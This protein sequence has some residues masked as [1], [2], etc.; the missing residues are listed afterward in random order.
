MKR[1]CLYPFIP[2]V[3]IIIIV[4]S[5][6]YC[7]CQTYPV[8]AYLGAPNV[9]GTPLY[10]SPF[11]PS[12]LSTSGNGIYST[13]YSAPPQNPLPSGE[14]ETVRAM[15]VKDNYAYYIKETGVA[16]SIPEQSLI[17][18]DISNTEKPVIVK[19]IPLDYPLYDII[20][21]GDYLYWLSDSFLWDM[22]YN[23]NVDEYILGAIDISNPVSP[24]MADT[25]KLRFS[26]GTGPFNMTFSENRLYIVYRKIEGNWDDVT[27]SI[28]T[29]DNSNP[30]N[31][32][33]LSMGSVEIDD[34]TDKVCI[35]DNLAFLCCSNIY[36]FDIS[37]PTNPDRVS[38]IRHG[39]S[40]FEDIEVFGDFLL[41]AVE[42]EGLRIM[43]IKDISSPQLITSLE[44]SWPK[45]IIIKDHYAYISDHC[46]GLYVVDLTDPEKPAVLSGYRLPSFKVYRSTSNSSES[47]LSDM[48]ITDGLALTLSYSN[49]Q[50]WDISERG[51]IQK[52][53]TLGA[54]FEQDSVTESIIPGKLI[55]LLSHTAQESIDLAQNGNSLTFGVDPLDQLNRKYGV[56]RI[57]QGESSEIPEIMEDYDNYKER[58]Y[59]IEFQAGEDM[60]EVWD[61][62]MDNPYCLIAEFIYESNFYLN[63]VTGSPQA[64]VAEPLYGRNVGGFF[65]SPSAAAFTGI[66]FPQTPPA[67]NYSLFGL[68]NPFQQNFGIS[69]GIINNITPWTLLS[70]VSSPVNWQI[71]SQSYRF[72][73]PYSLGNSSIS[74]PFSINFLKPAINPINFNNWF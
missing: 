28:I 2:L 61:A 73:S 33:Q 46:K 38:T 68:N 16:Y 37:D 17:I 6:H 39:Q 56:Y 7:W 18:A 22:G 50:I 3:I 70:P 31:L 5:L 43:D 64:S 40:R 47:W 63:G 21:H 15:E 4:F 23:L 72:G 49:I 10:G 51:N 12:G 25:I 60:F 74:N 34:I 65:Y 52:K 27:Q 42:Y 53:G 20:I 36:I 35:K 45:E 55:L 66:T 19:S 32:I 71:P 11:F 26:Q 1:F 8:R 62:Y 59:S 69:S 24:T 58:I 13:V 57:T 48:G 30:A 44:M 14:L 29:I 54:S 67:A 41:I 9:Y